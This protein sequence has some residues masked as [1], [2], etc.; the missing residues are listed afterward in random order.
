MHQI[1]GKDVHSGT[2]F[3]HFDQDNVDLISRWRPVGE[4]FHE[5][6]KFGLDPY[7]KSFDGRILPQVQGALRDG[8]P[9]SGVNFASQD[10]LSLASH[11]D[12]IAAAI[13]AA[14]DL[15]VHS[16]GSA[17]LMGIS[18]VALKLERALEDYLR[19]REVTLFPTGWTAGY[20]IVKMLARPGD[21]VLID[22]LAHACLQEGAQSSGAKVHRFPHLSYEGVK[23]RLESVRKTEPSAGILV[24]TETLFSMDSDTP[25]LGAL[26]D[27]CRSHNAT[28]LVDCA[29]DLGCMGPEGLGVLGTKDLVGK[30]DVLIGTFSKTFASI[31]G[32]VATQHVGFRTAL[33]ACC[34][35]QTFTN[36][37]TPL[38]ASVVL[39]A[40][41]VVRGAEGDQRREKMIVNVQALRG[42]LEAEKFKVLGNPSAI[43]PVIVGDSAVA[44]QMTNAMLTGGAIVNLVEAPAVA[45]N[46][47]RWRLQV[48]ADHDDDTI[49]AFVRIAAAS[50][51]AICG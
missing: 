34:G 36:A 27:L 46:Q 12:L 40:L 18:S 7:Q 50:R 21:H 15:G 33:R 44:R 24:V 3:D 10:Y 25:D 30:I 45:K 22:V 47:S 16:A 31:G 43:V 38:Q 4:W 1:V 41:D 17:A 26:Q 14:T 11:P 49:E 51:T 23:R 5:R 9:F 2:A 48:M 35:P 8:R 28:L 6:G 32:F 20:G 39:A 42:A 29:H 13:R 37:M 19:Y